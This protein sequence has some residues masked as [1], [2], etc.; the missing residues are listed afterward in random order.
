MRSLLTLAVL[1]VC[2]AP[3]AAA[4]SPRVVLPLNTGW[5]FKKTKESTLDSFVSG[6]ATSDGWERVT[7]PHTWNATDAQSGGPMYEGT[8]WYRRHLAF[9]PAWRGKRVFL[10]FDGV[11]QS[12]NVWVNGRQVGSGHSGAYSAFNEDLTE[13]LDSLRDNIV[14]VR[15][16]NRMNPMVI[17]T[18]NNL[19]MVFGG[20]YRPVS[21]IIT[22]PVHIGAPSLLNGGSGVVIR[23]RDV[24]VASARIRVEVKIDAAVPETA[25]RLLRVRIRDANGGIAAQDTFRMLLEPDSRGTVGRELVLEHPH[26]WNGRRDPYLYRVDVE[27]LDRNGVTDRV[28]QPLGVRSYRIDATKGFIL[29]GEPYRLY[30]VARH[31]EWQ[32]KGSALTDA[33]HRRDMELM[34]EMGVTSLRLAHYQQ[35]E[36]MYAMADSLGILVWAEIPWVNRATGQEANNAAR[37]LT[38]LILQNQN[39]PSIFV[40]GLHNEV[41]AK[42]STDAQV[43]LTRRLHAVAKELDP[44]RPTVTTSGYGDLNRPMNWHADLQA[45]NRYIGW[46]DDGGM[47]GLEAWIQ[48]IERDRPQGGVAIG[49][50]GAEGN[51]MQHSENDRTHGDPEKGQFF[52]EEYQTRFHETQWAQIARHPA[53]WASYVWNM[54]DFTV[55]KWN[56][57]GVAARNQKG[58]VTYDRQTK[59]DAFYFYK[60]NWTTTPVL[61]IADTRLVTRTKPTM[62]LTVYSNLGAPTA[63]VRGRSLGVPRSGGSP[64]HWVWPDVPL[65]AGDNLVTVTVTRNGRRYSDSTHF[66]RIP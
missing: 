37:Q 51:V 53:I 31:Q 27:L 64:A 65:S 44:D 58:L 48:S 23:A 54:F 20:I 63:T 26:L 4:Q 66:H 10:H 18:N 21:L 49:E 3:L 25:R 5:E 34:V 11:G 46:Y 13:A 14:L 12:A 19:F 30:G 36:A 38:E 47:E 2:R 6:L 52:P 60:A 8:G 55:P 17:P 15:A 41:Y 43:A 16:D 39:H 57:G 24:S 50:Y 1:L 40:W 32:D 42:D 28:T 9:D 62:T 59:K 22:E 56:R 35:S 45:M 33:E 29:N 61:H 7:L